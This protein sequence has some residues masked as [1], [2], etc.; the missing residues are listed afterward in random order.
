MIESF[1]ETP[2]FWGGNLDLWSYEVSRDC[3]RSMNYQTSHFCVRLR[4]GVY[5]RA[6]PL[7][8]TR[9][10]AWLR[11]TAYDHKRSRATTQN[12]FKNFLKKWWTIVFGCTWLRATHVL[13]D[14]FGQV[15]HYL[16]DFVRLRAAARSYAAVRGHTRSRAA[17]RIHGRARSRAT[18]R[19]R[20]WSRA[21]A[22]DRARRVYEIKT[23]IFPWKP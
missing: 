1:H 16:H 23:L 13:D 19:T 11:A 10:R 12:H 18:I 14:N 6:P 9:D 5:G 4:A 20:A 22:R 15:L 2:N 7:M 8:A 21:V 17:I 3:A